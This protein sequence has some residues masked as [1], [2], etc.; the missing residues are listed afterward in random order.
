MKLPDY[1]HSALNA[2]SSILKNY[3]IKVEYPTL[4]ELDIILRKKYQNIVY[5]LLDGLGNFWLEKELPHSFLLKK[6]ESI[7]SAVFPP[8]TTAAMT[9]YYSGLAPIS[10]GWLGWSCYFKEFDKYI[11]LFSGNESAERIPSM[12]PYHDL[13]DYKDIFLR[14]K[15]VKQIKTYSIFP[16]FV[17]ANYQ[18]ELIKVANDDEL[19]N[20]ILNLTSD[21][22][23]KFILAYYHKPDDLMHE[24][25]PYDPRVKEYMTQL[26]KKIATLYEKINDDTLIIISADH[27]QISVEHEYFLEDYPDIMELLVRKPCIEPRALSF[28]IKESEKKK[29]VELFEKY[30]NKDFYLFTKEEALKLELFGPGTPH[31]KSLDFLGDF[32]A[33]GIGNALMN[34]K[35]LPDRMVFKGHHA[36]MKKEEIEIPLIILNKGIK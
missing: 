6:R 19:L 27:G 29:F 20:S 2:I 15:E 10:H 35:N 36:G 1:H 11:D 31:P 25:G 13:I 9:V 5:L 4:T 14:I 34:Y 32:L 22:E 28:F 16:D 3:N 24:Y 26:D 33:V 23:E 18:S 12:V 17:N 8:T 21:K 30:F 7:L